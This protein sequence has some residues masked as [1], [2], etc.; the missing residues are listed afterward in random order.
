MT[1]HQNI[2]DGSG[3]DEMAL[4]FRAWCVTF[5]LSGSSFLRLCLWI[6]VS[7]HALNHSSWLWWTCESAVRNHNPPHS[8][9]NLVNTSLQ[10]WQTVGFVMLSFIFIMLNGGFGLWR[11]GCLWSWRCVFV[12]GA[13]GDTCYDFIWYLVWKICIGQQRA[14][15]CKRCYVSLAWGFIKDGKLFLGCWSET[16]FHITFMSW[17]GVGVVCVS[18]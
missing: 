14:F 16:H 2:A 11:C 6:S 4:T 15:I 9:F 18:D 7:A 17:S 1:F 13:G 12:G 5:R 3:G 10:I 8:T